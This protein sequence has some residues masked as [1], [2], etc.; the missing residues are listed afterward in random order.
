MDDM[1]IQKSGNTKGK[2]YSPRFDIATDFADP[3]GHSG[4]SERATS[5]LCCGYNPKTPKP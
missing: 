5:A 4:F 2:M 3:V 1:K